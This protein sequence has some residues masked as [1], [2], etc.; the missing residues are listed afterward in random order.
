M[1]I[2]ATYQA[3]KKQFPNE[4]IYVIFQ[5]HQLFR[6]VSYQKD[7]EKVLS[8]IENLVIYDIYSV[9]EEDLLKKVWEQEGNTWTQNTNP[10][11]VIKTIWEKIAKKVGWQYIDNFEDLLQ[12][13]SDKNWIVLL[14]TA[15]DL[16]YKM[17]KLITK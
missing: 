6:F 4:N 13:L 15:G 5:P 10:K 3:F 12:Y 8:E 16:D 17:R 9:R 11:E 7:F 14:M 2:K 1:E